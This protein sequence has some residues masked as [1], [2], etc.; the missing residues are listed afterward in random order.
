MTFAESMREVLAKME[1]GELPMPT[2]AA[3]VGMFGDGVMR[4][5]GVLD[6][7]VVQIPL[8]PEAMVKHNRSRAVDEQKP[9]YR[10]SEHRRRKHKPE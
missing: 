2:R 5:F 4:A 10:K 9:G 3:I 1:R 7:D 8:T 6:G